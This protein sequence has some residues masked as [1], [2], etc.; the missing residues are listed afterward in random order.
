MTFDGSRS[1]DA[2]AD[3][4]LGAFDTTNVAFGVRNTNAYTTFYS[5]YVQDEFKVNPR[6]T[7][8]FGL[9]YE[10]FLPWTESKNAINTVR[11]GQQS[12]VVP[13]APPGIVFPGDHGIAPVRHQVASVNDVEL[14][15]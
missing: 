5:G 13:D 1:G 9:R 4:L 10:P 3:F 14:S 2:F 8:T 12:T 11:I 6:F 15:G 7:L